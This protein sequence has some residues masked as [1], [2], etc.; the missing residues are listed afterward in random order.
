MTFNNTNYTAES[1][2]DVLS[3]IMNPASLGIFKD[4]GLPM[5]SRDDVVLGFTELLSR[6]C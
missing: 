2:S 6:N 5:I 1:E 4:N 3:Y